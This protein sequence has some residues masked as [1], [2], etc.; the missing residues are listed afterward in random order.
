[1]H[2]ELKRLSRKRGRAFLSKRASSRRRAEKLRILQEEGLDA[3]KKTVQEER[4]GKQGTHGLVVCTENFELA[5]LRLTPIE[6]SFTKDTSS[7][8]C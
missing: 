8:C 3:L 6:G 4:R 1:M 7:S 2:Q 5:V